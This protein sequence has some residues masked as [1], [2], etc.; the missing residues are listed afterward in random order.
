M[1]FP[2][3]LIAGLPTKVL[4]ASTVAPVMVTPENRYSN[5]MNAVE[6]KP[7][8]P[9]PAHPTKIWVLVIS[10]EK[11]LMLEYSKAADTVIEPASIF[12][13]DVSGTRY[14]TS[15]VEPIRPACAGRQS[16]MNPRAIGSDAIFMI[17]PSFLRSGRHTNRYPPFSVAA[18][19]RQTQASIIDL[20]FFYNDLKDR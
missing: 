16:P 9:G 19:D 10:T 17:P 5:P 18:R 8:L 14:R 2:T 20:L 1:L 12:T 15:T 11:L 4:L 13:V 7:R 6:A 3:M